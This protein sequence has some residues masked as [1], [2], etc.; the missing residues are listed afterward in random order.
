MGSMA[1]RLM[2]L[3]LG[4][5]MRK[6]RSTRVAADMRPA[7]QMSREVR[8]SPRHSQMVVPRTATVKMPAMSSVTDVLPLQVKEVVH[9]ALSAPRSSMAARAP[10]R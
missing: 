4:R 2:W 9:G 8:R 10:D 3:P 6:Q 5:V 7:R 1:P